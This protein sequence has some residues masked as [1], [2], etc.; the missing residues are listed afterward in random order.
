MTPKNLNRAIDMAKRT[1]VGPMGP[2]LPEHAERRAIRERVGFSRREAALILGCTEV[3][4]LRWEKDS[5]PRSAFDRRSY[6]RL[7]QTMRSWADEGAE[8]KR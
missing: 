4:L 5:D 2:D 3:T 6:R 8:G 1:E 7:L